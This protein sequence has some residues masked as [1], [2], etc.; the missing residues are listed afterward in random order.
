M[1]LET[2]IR[3]LLTRAQPQSDADLK[4]LHQA[5]YAAWSSPLLRFIEC[6]PWQGNTLTHYLQGFDAIIALSPRA[7]QF[8]QPT[9]W[10][11][12]CDYYAIGIASARYWRNQGLSV[13]VPATSTSEGMLDLL[14][15]QPQLASQRCLILRGWI[16]RDWLIDPLRKQAKSVLELCC[17]RQVPKALPQSVIYAWQALRINFIVCNSQQQAIHL[18]RLC[19]IHQALAWLKNCAL[20][21]PSS[22][23]AEQLKRQH[24]D[25]LQ[26]YDCQGA[27]IQSVQTTLNRIQ[28][29]NRG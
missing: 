13:Q 8:C 2:D 25:C 1:Q 23:V 14:A 20:L 21:V 3:L 16:S 12:S 15:V 19:K 28:A 18:Y 10:P 5:G 4:V 17:Y 27:D 26:I 11:R 9:E 7:S 22:R 24:L 29:M 6:S